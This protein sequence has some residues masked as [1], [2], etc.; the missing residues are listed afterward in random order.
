MVELAAES[1]T[2]T[3]NVGV[4]LPRSFQQQP[5]ACMHRCAGGG[6]SGGIFTV[7]LAADGTANIV[8]TFPTTTISSGAADITA[9]P[10]GKLYVVNSP[11]LGS[12]QAYEV[13]LSHV[14][15]S[16]TPLK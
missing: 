3:I 12:S 9:A 8:G 5:Y 14:T 7:E 1:S 15:H 4:R 6:S 13:G 2:N 10:N 11:S 16:V